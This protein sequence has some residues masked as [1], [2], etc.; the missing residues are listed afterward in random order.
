M[1]LGELLQFQMEGI[2]TQNFRDGN[3]MELHPYY[4]LIL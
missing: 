2:G 3:S 4:F 1:T